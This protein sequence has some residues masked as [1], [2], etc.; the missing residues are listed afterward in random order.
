MTGLPK[1][2]LYISTQKAKG[3]TLVLENVFGKEGNEFYLVNMVAEASKHDISAAVMGS[4]IGYFI[5]YAD[6][7]AILFK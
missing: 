3:M 4:I 5:D 2:R 6:S 1:T 7:D